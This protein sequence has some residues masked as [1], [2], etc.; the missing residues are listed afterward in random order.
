MLSG[1][2]EILNR[3]DMY[4]RMSLSVAELGIQIPQAA[5]E[6]FDHIDDSALVLSR[7][8][9]LLG[10]FLVSVSLQLLKVIAPVQTEKVSGVFPAKAFHGLARF[11]IANLV[12]VG[13]TALCCKQQLR[14]L[15]TP[16]TSR[17]LL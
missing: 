3:A 9:V 5:V 17:L 1:A 8:R 16:D 12:K 11:S 4:S 14:D 15:S 6:K 10:Y 7:T 2:A 13:A